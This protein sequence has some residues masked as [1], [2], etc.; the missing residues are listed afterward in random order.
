MSPSPTRTVGG[1]G[2]A[3]AVLVAIVWTL[4]LTGVLVTALRPAPDAVAL[5]W[6]TVVT[7]PSLTVDHLRTVLQGEGPVRSMWSATWSSLAISLPATV[8]VV[9]LGLGAAYAL[10]WT[11]GRSRRIL[12]LVAVALLFVPLQAVLVPLVSA[13]DDT[14]LRGSLPGLWLAHAAFGLPL[15]VVLLAAAIRTVPHD[16]VDAARTDGAGHL[17]VLG[18]VVTPLVAPAVLGVALLQFLVVWNDLLV[19]ATLLGDP[20]SSNAPLPLVLA[21]IVRTWPNELHL[22]GAAVLVTV[23]VPLVV[24]A[25]LH[26]VLTHTLV[27]GSNPSALLSADT[28]RPRRAD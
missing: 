28:P 22:H 1:L 19:S 6:W 8:L 14:G 2:R 20:R 15:A 21:D 5:G 17:A 11:T 4:P 12:H 24:F 9:A 3:L 10:V 7:D 13:Y 18:R 26:R 27:A 23:A 25:V 16:L